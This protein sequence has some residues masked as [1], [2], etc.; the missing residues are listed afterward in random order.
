MGKYRIKINESDEF[1][2]E[3]KETRKGL[4]A[5]YISEG[6]PLLKYPITMRPLLAIT[7]FI[8]WQ[9]QL[10]QGYDWKGLSWKFE[11]TPDF[12]VESSEY[13]STWY[14]TEEDVH[15]LIDAHKESLLKKSKKF[16]QVIF[17][18]R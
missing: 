15:K 6:K 3:F 17:E 1:S 8:D 9:I 5:Y 12:G 16:E 11:S 4:R 2:A 10:V 7:F 14:K 13:V 18:S